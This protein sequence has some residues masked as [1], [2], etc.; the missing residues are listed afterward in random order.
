MTKNQKAIVE[1]YERGYRV[2]VDGGVTSFTGRK[3]VLTTSTNKTHKFSIYKG[4]AGFTAVLVGWER[5][6]WVHRLQA[7]QKYGDEMFRPNMVVRHKN[8][9]STDNP[10][11]NILLGTHSQ[12][13][14]D[15]AP[16]DRIKYAN[17]ASSFMQRKD[18]DIIDKDRND[19]LSYRALQSKYGVSKGTLSYRYGTGEGQHRLMV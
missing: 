9:D 3:L 2:D 4:Y 11:A 15:I 6:V 12:N 5:K 16:E 13:S 7:Y 18:W 19:G 10:Y 17:Y 8:G 1:A 14:L